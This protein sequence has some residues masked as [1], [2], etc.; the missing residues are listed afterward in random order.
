MTKSS[1]QDLA[2]VIHDVR[3]PLNRISMQAELIKLVLENDLAK[4]KA[5]AAVEKIIQSCQDCSS[6][7]QQ[8]L[9]DK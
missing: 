9:T 3:K 5:L 4:D 8:I 6:Q 1:Q 2:Q 7:L